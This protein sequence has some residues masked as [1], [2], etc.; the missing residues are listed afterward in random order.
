MYNV[1][2]ASVIVMQF[3]LVGLIAFD[4][5]GYH[6]VAA[7]TEQLVLVKVAKLSRGNDQM[8]FLVTMLEEITIDMIPFMLI[9]LAV[10]LTQVP[11]PI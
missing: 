9:I 4:I 1:V 3:S 11:Q 7:L 2:D 8:S 10:L 5:N 6:T